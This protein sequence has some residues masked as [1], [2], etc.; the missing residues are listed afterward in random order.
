MALYGIISGNTAAASDV[1]QL[2]QIFNGKHDIGAIIFAP[3]ISAPS[4][5]SFSL[6][7][8]AGNSLGVGAYNYK[9]TYVTG[10]YKSD[11]ITLVQTGETTPS[12]T[13]S[14]TTTSGNT[15][16]LVTLPTRGIPVSAI[17][18]NI[19]RT[20]VG[21]S[22]YKLVATVKAGSANYSDSVA[23]ASRGS[24]TPPVSNTTG[25]NISVSQINGT[26][27]NNLKLIAQSG[28]SVVLQVAGQGDAV[29]VNGS[30]IQNPYNTGNITLTAGSGH[31][32]V[33]VQSPTDRVY[34]ETNIEV[35]VTKPGTTATYMP[36]LASAFT[37][38]SIEDAKTNIVPW[39]ISALEII[40]KSVI[41]EYNLKTELADGIEKKRHGFVIGR[42]T[43]EEVIDN[44]A[45]DIYGMAALLVKAIQELKNENEELKMR[46]SNLEARGRED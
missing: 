26:S 27:G 17:A 2:I 1:E 5:G 34:L 28:T 3:Q 16:V 32:Y 12:A 14:I 9:F 15:T 22:D 35:R 36:I 13:L 8:Q 39:D 40:D 38:N 41:Y 21:G 25:N 10:Q 18:I 37:V 7:T 33:V 45:I 19:Y 6:S 42:E 24:Q 30:K 23:D 20:S 43:P 4:S 46:I 11:G 44:D 29:T 31:G